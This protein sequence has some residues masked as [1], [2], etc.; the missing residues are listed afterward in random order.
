MLV[1]DD[2]IDKANIRR[3]RPSMHKKLDAYLKN[4][5]N[6]KFNGEDLT[7]V[8]GDIMHAIAIHAFLAINEELRRKEKALRKCIE[9]V[10]YTGTGEF[11]ELLLG[12][13]TIERI[14]PAE[15]YRVYDLKT[16]YYT[17]SCPLAAGAI[18]A[19][20]NQKQVDLLFKSGVYLGRAFQIKDDI[21]GMF[22]EEAKIGKSALAD[23]KEAKKTILIWRAFKSS[24]KK[25]RLAIKKLLAKEKVNK[26]DLLKMRKIIA[27][28]GAL[29]YAKK[30]ILRFLT[31]AQKLI[32]SSQ[33][34]NR[35]KKLLSRYVVELL[36][37]K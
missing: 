7:I 19:G 33:M 6:I 20:A 15:I 35:Y 21:L 32:A 36:S 34:Q 17:F 27:A 9:A 4:F 30:E 14:T 13:K 25:N 31:Q 22:A 5:K 10:V 11:I 16:A 18:L 24:N 1:H 37:L 3:G 2:I 8:A 29:N 12:L 26:S 23:L 28:A